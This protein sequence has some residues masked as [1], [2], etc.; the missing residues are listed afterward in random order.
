MELDHKVSDYMNKRNVFAANIARIIASQFLVVAVFFCACII[1]KNTDG[2]KYNLDKIIIVV[3]AIL[4]IFSLLIALAGVFVIHRFGKMPELLP[5]SIGLR[6]SHDILEY[7]YDSSGD[8]L[9]FKMTMAGV[10][11]TGGVAGA[12]IIKTICGLSDNGTFGAKIL[13]FSALAVSAI[14]FIPS[15]DRTMVYKKMMDNSI[16]YAA[17]NQTSM[18][19]RK[20]MWILFVVIMPLTV[21]TYLWWRYL[22]S[23]GSIAFIVY[24]IV[25][26]LAGTIAALI[27][28]REYNDEKMQK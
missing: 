26:M 22:S 19:N 16:R 8:A 25:I 18:N 17:D 24:P 10:M 23:N 9:K 11:L 28:Y 2:F 13:F 12:L 20:A 7:A 4:V 1:L 6:Q 14:L 3:K 15:F 5:D 27:N 21:C